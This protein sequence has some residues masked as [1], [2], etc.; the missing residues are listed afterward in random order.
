VVTPACL[1]GRNLHRR[2]VLLGAAAFALRGLP[3]GAAFSAQPRLA[4]ID[5]AA[6]ETLIAIGITPVAIADLGGFRASFSHLPEM[7]GTV[8]LGSTWEPNLELLD[9]LKPDAIY[10]PAWSSLSLAQLSDIAP[11]RLCDIHGTGGDPTERALRFAESLLVD[12]PSPSGEATIRQ[13]DE[14]LAQLAG[15]AKPQP[16]FLLNLR[17]SNRFVNVYAGGSLP[18]S[19]LMHVGLQNAWQGPVNGFGFAS[20]GTEKLLQAS[21][22]SIVI[23]NQN[24]RTAEMLA[25]LNDSIFWSAI[26]AVRA[27]K[28]HVS[29]PVSVFGGLVSATTFAEWLAVTFDKAV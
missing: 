14:R 15:K 13:L 27:G 1:S 25:R 19:A 11:V 7:N 9:R 12:F 20:I 22:V 18:G 4:A 3:A 5:W 2:A 23:L 26:P 21:D 29:P 10:L 6:A 17:S 24:D 28:I 16:V 8:D